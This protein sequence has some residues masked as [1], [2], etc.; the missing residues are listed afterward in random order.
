MVWLSSLVCGEVTFREVT[1]MRSDSLNLMDQERSS[2]QLLIDELSLL[3]DTIDIQVWYLSDI[4]TYG[5]VN[6]AHAAFF[7]FNH[8]TMQFKKISTFFP[9]DIVELSRAGNRVVFGEKRRFYA[10][11]WLTNVEGER[12]LL[13]V[14]KVPKLDA[15][16]NVRFAVCTG[17]DITEHKRTE[18]MLKLR[19]EE[20][21]AFAHTMAHDITDS[22]TVMTVASN[23]LAKSYPSMSHEEI[24]FLLEKM[25]RSSKKTA[26]VIREMLFFAR[27][28]KEEVTLQSF[29]M[30]AVVH[31]ALKRLDHLIVEHRAEIN[32][33]VSF[34][35]V[36]GHPGWVEEVWYNLLNNAIAYG[37][38]P[39]RIQL[40]A[41]VLK[42]GY[43]KFWAKDNGAGLSQEALAQVRTG[44][45]H[46]ALKVHGH[47]FG[48]SIVHR[49][50]K[51]LGGEV[52]A[53]SAEGKGSVFSFTLPLP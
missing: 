24:L 15:E 38:R 6:R 53:E 4:E 32:P 36:L 40:G 33:G 18:T 13:A 46:G 20:L 25:Q 9:P 23:T 27:L 45:V 47:G 3:L 14:T 51:K 10:E 8:E 39:P 41:R 34:P 26:N 21:D 52:H 37:G 43:A 2:P 30:R 29:D 11:E 44:D 48:L 50:V 49:I 22:L 42:N 7:G 17:V 12:R 35:A 1:P 31:E 16:G 5:R 19:N 28:H